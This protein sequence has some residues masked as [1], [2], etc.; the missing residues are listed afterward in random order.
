MLCGALCRTKM[1]KHVL[2]KPCVGLT[3]GIGSGKSSA[4]QIFETLGIV[5]ADTDKI[6]REITAKNGQ[7]IALIQKHFGKEFIC[8]GAL[9]RNMMR[10][11][12]FENS[13]LKKKLE[14]ILH[15]IIEKKSLL[16]VENAASPYVILDVPLLFEVPHFLK[17]CWRVL[18]IDC[19]EDLQIQ[20]V[21]MR[22]A[23]DLA[24]IRAVIA[25]Q[26]PREKRLKNA[27]DVIKN[28]GSLQDLNAQVQKMHSFYLKLFGQTS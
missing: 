8:N 17:Y 16:T 19:P 9:N 28:T 4:L 11:A 12:V 21:L 5:A 7:A 18:V 2:K 24:S 15:P 3:G 1:P 13:A 27:D 26:T 6:A 20:R 25:A 23:W 10:R 14:N 22:N